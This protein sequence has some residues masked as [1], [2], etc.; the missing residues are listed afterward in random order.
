MLPPPSASHW[1]ATLIEADHMV[2]H[3]LCSHEKM[4]IDL[5]CAEIL[6]LTVE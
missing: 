5:D 4:P 2:K 3:S 6:R 1:D